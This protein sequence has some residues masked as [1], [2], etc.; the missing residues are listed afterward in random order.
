[1]QVFCCVIEEEVVPFLE[2]VNFLV[3]FGS[4]G[5]ELL[6]ARRHIL[7]PAVITQTAQHLFNVPKCHPV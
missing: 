6:R 2:L 3:H 1:M 4:L 7:V 5:T